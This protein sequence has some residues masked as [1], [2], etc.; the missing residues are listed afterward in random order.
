[1]R[2]FYIEGYMTSDGL[3][4]IYKKFEDEEHP[5]SLHIE[6]SDGKGN[7]RIMLI[8]GADSIQYFKIMLETLACNETLFNDFKIGWNGTTE[9]HE[10]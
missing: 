1:M 2:K 8:C 5:Y 10:V 9:M 4:E 7:H 6:K 3:R